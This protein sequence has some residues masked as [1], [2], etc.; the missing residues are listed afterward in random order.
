MQAAA[1]AHRPATTPIVRAVKP[2]AE[3]RVFVDAYTTTTL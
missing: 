3:D 2:H 1:T